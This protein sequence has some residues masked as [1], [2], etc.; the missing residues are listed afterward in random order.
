VNG[1]YYVTEQ[2]LSSSRVVVRSGAFNL[3]GYAAS[4][5]FVLFL[6][7]LIVHYVG[8]EM[9]G[10]WSLMLALT[11]YLGLAD[12]GLAT[13]FTKYV[14]EFSTQKDPVRVNRVMTHG[15]VFYAVLSLVFLVVGYT[16]F[17]YLFN[18]LNIP[19]QQFENARTIFLLSLL[20]FGA[21]S[22]GSVFASILSGIQRTDLLSII[23]SI[24]FAVKLAA[25][26]ATLVLGWGISAMVSA[27]VLTTVLTSIPLYLASKRCLPYLEIRF[28]SYDHALMKTLLRFGSHLQVSRVAEAILLQFDKLL[29][30]RFVGL[31]SV[32]MYDFGSRPLARL[33]ALEVSSVGALIPAI[34]ELQASNNDQRIVSAMSR[35]SKYLGMM[36]FPV[37]GFLFF[38]ADPIIE[39]WLGK[40]YGQAAL[41]MKILVVS[42][43]L[44]VLASPVGFVGQG[45]GETKY[46]MWVAAAQSILNIVLSFTLIRNFG[47]FGAVVGT[48]IAMCIGA[49]LLIAWYG[50][51]VVE[52]PVALHVKLW[53]KPFISSLLALFSV[54]AIFSLIAGHQERSLLAMELVL[55]LVSAVVLCTFAYRWTKT[56]TQDDR[57]FLAGVLP[58]KLQR[59]LHVLAPSTV[60]G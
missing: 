58:G 1:Y 54:R 38:F 24:A 2:N 15:L 17:P 26:S 20:S 3:L 29:I 46:Q 27:D 55:A 44:N 60:G 21:S 19:A 51:R 43:C 37:F 30:S 40:G 39:V 18:L 32:S 7:P 59:A 22:I 33:R 11:G 13:S 8:A 56:L 9:F 34:S 25:M 49:L 36:S 35:S 6:V 12:V 31:S 52:N 48:A 4:S 53:M 45:R 14:A 41:T 10:L 42:Y 28:R 57:T 16:A 50:K 47:Y 5:L 23:M